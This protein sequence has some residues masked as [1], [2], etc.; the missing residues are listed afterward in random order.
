M[1]D[2][3]R[4]DDDFIFIKQEIEKLSGA[5]FPKVIER[6]QA[7]FSRAK[8][9]RV[10]GYCLLAKAY[11]NGIEGFIDGLQ[12]YQT[13]ID[14][15]Y[16]LAINA[17]IAAIQWLNQPRLSNALP[18]YVQKAQYVTL[19]QL[20]ID[21]N[22]TLKKTF[23]EQNIKISMADEWLQKQHP[24]F[25]ETPS[26]VSTVVTENKKI[27]NSEQMLE[28]NTRC[29]VEYL[30]EQKMLLRACAYARAWRWS[31][32]V[33]PEHKLPP[34]REPSIIQLQ[35]ALENSDP[36]ALFALCEDL[37]LEPSG[38]VWLD[39][40]Y[41][42]FQA[43]MAL[44][45]QPLANFILS[46]LRNLLE[47]VPTLPEQQFADEKPYA[48]VV[49]KQWLQEILANKKIANTTQVFDVDT[50]LKNI[51]NKFKIKNKTKDLTGVLEQ[52]L[53]I[54][55][56]DTKSQFLQQQ[57]IS[58]YCMQHQR[59]DLAIP[60]L[61]KLNQQIIQ[62]H[63]AQ[64][65]PGL[66]VSVWKDLYQALVVGLKESDGRAEAIRYLICQTDIRQGATL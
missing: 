26:V 23:P 24:L 25:E 20:I 16:P 51:K 45:D 27:V 36:E 62:Y 21:F 65:D 3:P 43:A 33:L 10:A 34:P 40:Q 28:E 58:R 1:T 52:L 32:L 35:R 14:D 12:Y 22:N 19:N 49:T 30:H 37:F 46:Q 53:A 48:N 54:P 4:Y 38:H 8:D 66:A 6:A 13:I 31:E 18:D 15:A 42:A 11:V 44:S 47:R 7:F 60:L 63:L 56:I 17:K 61:E 5:D 64:W 57:A 2:D 9:L 50:W 41:H 55:A 39:L 59:Y 29:I